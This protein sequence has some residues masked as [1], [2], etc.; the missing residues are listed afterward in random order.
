MLR[1]IITI[2]T[3]IT[4][5]TRY[6]PI[7]MIVMIVLPLLATL[8]EAIGDFPPAL[9]ATLNMSPSYKVVENE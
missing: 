9:G 6:R 1:S 5:H 2:I 7:V 8:P 3:I 4:L